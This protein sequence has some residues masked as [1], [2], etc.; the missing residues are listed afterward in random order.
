MLVSAQERMDEDIRC[1]LTDS[2]FASAYEQTAHSGKASPGDTR[3]F[4]S[5]ME[6][7]TAESQL[8]AWGSSYT[9]WGREFPDVVL[10]ESVHSH[11][12]YHGE[13]Y[14]PFLADKWRD[15]RATIFFSNACP[16]TFIKAQATGGALWTK[17]YWESD[18]A[19]ARAMS[20]MEQRGIEVEIGKTRSP[21]LPKPYIVI[22]TLGDNWGWLSSPVPGRCV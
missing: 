10:N 13:Y 6:V 9:F 19:Y 5:V 16:C 21:T 7:I 18:G 8:M 3:L 20:T 22:G 2:N 14:E 12:S 4:D 15:D 1:D 11:G 17:D